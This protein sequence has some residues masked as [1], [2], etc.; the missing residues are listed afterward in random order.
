LWEQS[1]RA[2]FDAGVR[3][4]IEFGPGSTLSGMIRRTVEAQTYHVEDA[5]SRDATAAALAEAPAG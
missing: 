3:R 5:A 4:F 2:M 1:V